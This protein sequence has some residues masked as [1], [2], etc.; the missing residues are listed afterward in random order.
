MIRK[1]F[2]DRAEISGTRR[3]ADGYLVTEAR[4]AR[5]GNIQDYAGWEIGEGKPT[6]V[7]R[8]YRPQ[9][10]I[11]KTDSLA[12]F[13]HKPVTMGHPENGV[14][15]QTWRKDAVGSVG[16]EVI[17]DGEFVRVPMVIM[18]AQAISDIEAGVREI[19]MGY[20]CELVMQ[21]G[22]TDD[23]RA[24]DAYQKNIRINHAAV[25]EMGRA[26]HSCRIGDALRTK[27]LEKD[28]PAMKTVT[29]D[30]K[31]LEVADDVAAV[32]AGLQDRTIKAEAT[33]SAF[34]DATTQLSSVVDQY[35]AKKDRE[36]A[37]AV[38]AA[39]E[40]KKSVPTA[41]QLNK[42]AAERSAVIDAA[43]KI[44]S[45]IETGDKS[46]ADIRK[47]AVALKI[48]D[49]AIKDK[50]DEYIGAMFDILG[51]TADAADPVAQAIRSSTA[52]VGDAGDKA[53]MDYRKELSSAWQTPVAK[54]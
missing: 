8:V 18:D 32:I 25:V 49:D 37:D 31:A 51:K 13:A 27:Q 16:S 17:R 54:N 53:F 44:D 33:A 39:D 7:F 11:F 5:G 26:G 2:A 52:H 47:A 6:D 14:T 28:T 36:V 9:D 42:M 35:K 3:T 10:E 24:Y 48:G 43:K 1:P 22:V 21:A 50:S 38:A 45:K 41:D 40:A 20:D 23:G 19:S 29:I 12:T 46:L 4:V 34:K 30:G 15:P